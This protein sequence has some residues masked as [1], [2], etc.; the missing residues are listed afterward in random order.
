MKLRCYELHCKAQRNLKNADRAPV[1]YHPTYN[2]YKIENQW[3][4]LVQLERRVEQ[5][6]QNYINH[7]ENRQTLRHQWKQEVSH[8]ILLLARSLRACGLRFLKTIAG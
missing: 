4:G 3:N 8:A 1:A 6:M 7:A 2:I 5:K